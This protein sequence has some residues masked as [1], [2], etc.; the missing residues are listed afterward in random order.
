MPQITFRHI[1][2]RILC[3]V[4]ASIKILCVMRDCKDVRGVPGVALCWNIRAQK[5]ALRVHDGLCC[6]QDIEISAIPCIL[7]HLFPVLANIMLVAKL[8]MQR[9]S[10]LLRLGLSPDYFLVLL[11]LIKLDGGLIHLLGISITD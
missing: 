6:A 3:I 11:S 9:S 8:S 10:P 4:S 1:E 5:G 2:L 7:L